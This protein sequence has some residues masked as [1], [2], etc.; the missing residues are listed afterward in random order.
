MVDHS[1]IFFDFNAMAWDWN[2]EGISDLEVSEDIVEFL[3]QNT[4]QGAVHKDT[5]EVL[6]FAAC[7][8]N[9]EFNSFVLSNVFDVSTQEVT[10]ICHV[11]NVLDHANVVA[12]GDGWIDCCGG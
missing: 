4:L 10:Q 11:A 9:R 1:L 5:I 7:L 12:C 6:K 2:E 8:G 3:V